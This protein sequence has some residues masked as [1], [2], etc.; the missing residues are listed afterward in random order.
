MH[1]IYVSYEV[2]NYY[3]KLINQKI[4]KN[5]VNH[6]HTQPLHDSKILI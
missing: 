2:I 5:R 4:L 3:E 6:K 1:E